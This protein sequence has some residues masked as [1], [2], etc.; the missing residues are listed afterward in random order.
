[1]LMEEVI[2]KSCLY[3]LTLISIMLINVNIKQALR[4]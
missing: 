3:N 1:M 4:C 2:I